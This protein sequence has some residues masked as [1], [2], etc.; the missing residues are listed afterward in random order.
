MDLHQW[1]ASMNGEEVYEAVGGQ[2]LGLGLPDH[3]PGPCVWKTVLTRADDCL[4]VVLA[5]TEQ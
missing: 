5:M 3:L 2:L 4:D 1:K